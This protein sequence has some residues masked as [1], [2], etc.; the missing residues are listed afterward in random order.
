MRISQG[1]FDRKRGAKAPLFLCACLAP[2]GIRSIRAKKRLK[3]DTLRTRTLHFA[4]NQIKGKE[5]EFVL[6]GRKRDERTD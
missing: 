2:C 1:K 3:N 5:L 4:Y 6:K